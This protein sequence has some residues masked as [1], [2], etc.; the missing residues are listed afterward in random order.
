MSGAT[1]FPA[2]LAKQSTETPGIKTGETLI[3]LAIPVVTGKKYLYTGH[4][5]DKN[6]YLK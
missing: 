3:Y 5:S 2:G 1:G 6:E 4:C